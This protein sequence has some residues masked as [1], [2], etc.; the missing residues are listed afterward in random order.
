MELSVD[1]G[2]W[3]LMIMLAACYVEAALRRDIDLEMKEDLTV[4]F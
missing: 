4:P 3:R 2:M 1:G